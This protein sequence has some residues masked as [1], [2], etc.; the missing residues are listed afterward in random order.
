[1][2]F[3][4]IWENFAQ[5]RFEYAYDQLYVYVYVQGST[6][7][8]Q[9]L[10]SNLIACSLTAQPQLYSSATFFSLHFNPLMKKF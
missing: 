7:E 1:M 3:R 8:I 5:V 9:T 2:Y 10:Y 4:N 6:I